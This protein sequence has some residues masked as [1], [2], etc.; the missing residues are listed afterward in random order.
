MINTTKVHNMKVDELLLEDVTDNNEDPEN[1]RI[2]HLLMQV[3][4]ALDHGGNHPIKFSDNTACTFP[5]ES[6]V[7]FYEGYMSLKPAGKEEVQQFGVERK[8]NF[9]TVVKYFAE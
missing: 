5:V 4:K 1:D 8:E 3:K 7:T 9:D 6:L 2:P